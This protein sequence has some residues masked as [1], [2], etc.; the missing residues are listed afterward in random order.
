MAEW[1]IIRRGLDIVTDKTKKNNKPKA[2]QETVQ[3]TAARFNNKPKAKQ[4]TAQ[5]TAA[6]F[7][8]HSFAFSEVMA[9]FQTVRETEGSWTS[10]EMAIIRG[11]RISSARVDPNLDEDLDHFQ[12]RKDDVF[13]ASYPKSGN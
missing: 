4:E 11:V 3:P 2:E 8:Q 12:T 6:R 10:P 7:K 9:T 13:V 1:D 5:P